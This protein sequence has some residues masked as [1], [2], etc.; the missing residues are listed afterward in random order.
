MDIPLEGR[1]RI[2]VASAQDVIRR[3]RQSQESRS[4]SSHGQEEV[5]IEEVIDQPVPRE[6]T[7]ETI[8]ENTAETAAKPARRVKF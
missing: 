4:E 6:P 7:P 5:E 3:H 1:N 8:A 2:S